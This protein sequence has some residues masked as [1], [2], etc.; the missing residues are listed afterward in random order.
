MGN[1][2]QGPETKQQDEDGMGDDNGQEGIGRSESTRCVRYSYLHLPQ[3]TQMNTP[4]CKDRLTTSPIA[5]H[6]LPSVQG[7]YCWL[8]GHV[9]PFARGGTPRTASE[10]CPSPSVQCGLPQLQP[11]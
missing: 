4:E 5:S 10:S 6:L 2:T 1:P 3:L 11:L 9:V 7:G 8:N